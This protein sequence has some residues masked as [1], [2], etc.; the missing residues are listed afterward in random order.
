MFMARPLKNGRLRMDTDLRIPVTSEQ[1]AMILEATSNEAEG[2]AAW[3][4]GILLEAAK[5]KTAKGNARE[6]IK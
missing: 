3:A 1:K 2:M 6:P 4:R 5:R